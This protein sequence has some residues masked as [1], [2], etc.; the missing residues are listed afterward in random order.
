MAVRDSGT[1]QDTWV[2]RLT[3]AGES[4]GV[5]DKKTGGA[6]DSDD[7][8]YYPGA[9]AEQI[10]LGGRKTTDNVTLQ[11]LYDRDDDHARINTLLRAAGKANCTVTQRPMDQEGNEY[12]RSITYR[13]K[14][15]RV[16]V[17]DVDSESSSAALVE[18]EISIN[19]FPEAV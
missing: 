8:K 14:V 2:V 18:V 16:A 12:G 1:R 4:F 17:P 6:V 5:W 9:M 10:S 15:K 11:R 3:V 13:G 7:Q 19:G